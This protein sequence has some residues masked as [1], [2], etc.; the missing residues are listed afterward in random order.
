MRF[1]IMDHTGHSVVK[2][3]TREEAQRMLDELVSAHST[4]A[5]R[6]YDRT[7]APFG[8]DYRVL[9]PVDGHVDLDELDAN[10]E[11]LAIPQLK[12]G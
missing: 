2:L 6:S 12:G 5:I 3:D 10:S 7:G 9:R 1:S 4:L 11:I 8:G